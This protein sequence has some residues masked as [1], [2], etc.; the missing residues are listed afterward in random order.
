MSAAEPEAAALV[1]LETAGGLAELILDRAVKLNAMNAAMVDQLHGA[2]DRLEGSAVRCLLLRAE[3]RAFSVGRDLV[4]ADPAHE[5][6]GA[7]LREL[8][9]PLMRRIAALPQPTFAAVQGPCLGTGLGLALACDIVYA[10]EDARIGS[11]FARVGAVLDSGA[12]SAFVGRI[13]PH[14]TLE[15]IYTGR[16]LSGREAADLGLVNASFPAGELLARTREAATAVASGPTTAFLESKRLVQRLSAEPLRLEEVLELEAQAQSRASLTHDYREGIGAF[17]E[18]RE[19][20]FTG[21]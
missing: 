16:L 15:L 6:G 2:L 19:P 3:G 21:R 18:K 12:H 8:F 5:D 13:G 1:R 20:H 4:E 17:Q 14:R 9:N 7:I 11:P 10:A